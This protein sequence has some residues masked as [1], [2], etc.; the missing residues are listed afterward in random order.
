MQA[1]LQSLG[2]E[3]KAL[4]IIYYV[5]KHLALGLELVLMHEP[6]LGLESLLRIELYANP[7]LVV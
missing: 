7:S 6:P 2:F 5:S 1:R 3:L 4:L